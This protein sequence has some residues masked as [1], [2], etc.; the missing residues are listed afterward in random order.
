MSTSSWMVRVQGYEKPDSESFEVTED[1]TAEKAAM[2][3]VSQLQPEYFV[4]YIELYYAGADSRA[5]ETNISFEICEKAVDI[6]EDIL[7]RRNA[8]EIDKR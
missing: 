8:R 5:G 4:E 7:E 3:A 6:T 1:V 2:N